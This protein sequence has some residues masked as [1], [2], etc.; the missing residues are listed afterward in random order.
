MAQHVRLMVDS[1][2]LPLRA[3]QELLRKT[4]KK[5]LGNVFS[6]GFRRFF[7]KSG[8]HILKYMTRSQLLQTNLAR[9]VTRWLTLLSTTRTAPL[10]RRERRHFLLVFRIDVDMYPESQEGNTSSARLPQTSLVYPVSSKTWA[11]SQSWLTYGPS[12]TSLLDED[13]CTWVKPRHASPTKDRKRRAAILRKSKSH[14]ITSS[15]RNKTPYTELLEPEER[16]F[17]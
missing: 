4:L 17:M 2:R 1:R 9:S 15:S 8:T 6:G 13:E 12:K 10:L 5:N 7:I 11:A 16:S 3:A 14:S